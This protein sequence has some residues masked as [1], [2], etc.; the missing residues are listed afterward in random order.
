MT[1]LAVR[2]RDLADRCRTKKLRATGG[3]LLSYRECAAVLALL[4]A[5]SEHGR[6]FGCHNDARLDLA[7]ANM[8]KP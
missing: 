6:S 3:L 4:D 2:L 8:E 5:A 7:L 1:P